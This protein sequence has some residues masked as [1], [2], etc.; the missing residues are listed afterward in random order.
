MLQSCYW[1]IE[2]LPGLSQQQQDGLKAC[3]VKTT[4]QL[5]A[6]SQKPQLK[7]LLVSQLKIHPQY[8]N[9]WIALADLARVPSVGHQYCGLLLHSGIA[10]VQQLSQTPVHRIHRQVLRLQV[11]NLQR[12]DLCPSVDLVQ[13]WVKEAKTLL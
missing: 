3:G 1:K 6:I 11:A 13:Q 12:K 2:Q 9:K 8:L 4:Q 5:L 10:S 7:Q